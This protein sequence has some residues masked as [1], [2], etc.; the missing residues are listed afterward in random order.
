MQFPFAV[1]STEEMLPSTIEAMTVFIHWNVIVMES[2]RHP[3]AN[4]LGETWPEKLA[5]EVSCGSAIGWWLQSKFQ[6]LAR[7][8]E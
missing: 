1:L 2:G 6:R 3:D 5:G 8:L 7:G 4:H